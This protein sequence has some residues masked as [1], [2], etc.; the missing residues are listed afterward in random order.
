MAPLV[1]VVVLT[2]NEEENI[3]KCLDSLLAQD[4]QKGKYEVIVVDAASKDRTQEICQKYP[5]RLLVADKKGFSYQR[6]RGVAA[7]RGKYIAF[8]DAD[9]VA[10]KSWLKKLVK[11]IEESTKNIAAVGGPNLVFE[12]DP[13]FSKI[14]GYMQETFLGSG[15]SAQSHKIGK[16]K[17]VSSVPNCNAIYR[18]QIIAEEK[19]DESLI[20]GDDCDLNFRLRQKGCKFLYRPDIIVWHRRPKNFKEFFKKVIHYGEVIGQ[21]TRKHKKVVRWYAF[22]VAFVILAVVF[23]YAIIRF[24]HPAIYIYA[25]AISLYIT[26]LAISTAQVYQR[27]KSIKS[28]MTMVL[29]PAQHLLYGLGFLKR[30]LKG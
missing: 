4:Y 11:Q 23:S 18:K 28:L 5:V 13:D 7:A 26:A 24:F 16:P 29:L 6:N 2:Y 25:F 20:G 17:L 15:G 19:Y 8:T 22:L 21:I 14:V 30:L 9:C 3:S 27:Y 12:D 10:E 1:S